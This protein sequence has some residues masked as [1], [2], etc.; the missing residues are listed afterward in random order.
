MA[1]VNSVDETKPTEV[2]ATTQSV[3][4]NFSV[5][6]TSDER[7]FDVVAHYGADKTGAT[8]AT[9]AFELAMTD[10]LA[11]GVNVITVPTGSYKMD[12][13]YTIPYG[14]H[15]NFQ[16]DA[17]I[18]VNN[19]TITLNGTYTANGKP[20]FDYSSG[21]SAIVNEFLRATDIKSPSKHK[22]GNSTTWYETNYTL[23]NSSSGSVSSYSTG[24]VRI[25]SEQGESLFLELNFTGFAN[26]IKVSFQDVD[27]NDKNG[28]SASYTT[29]MVSSV[30]ASSEL[31][32]MF[33]ADGLEKKVLIE[34][35]GTPLEGGTFNEE[36][37]RDLRRIKVVVNS[38]VPDQDA[39]FT[40]IS[41]KYGWKN[42]KNLK[43]K[44]P[45]SGLGFRHIS[46]RNANDGDSTDDSYPLY[47]DTSTQWYKKNLDNFMLEYKPDSLRLPINYKGIIPA[48]VI[49]H[50]VLDRLKE[51]LIYASKY[52]LNIVI[53]LNHSFT[54]SGFQPTRQILNA[55]IDTDLEA[56]TMAGYAANVVEF[57][58]SFPNI[59]GWDLENEINFLRFERATPITSVQLDKYLSEIS[60]EVLAV[61]KK[62]RIITMSSGINANLFINWALAYGEILD[63]HSYGSGTGFQNLM[64]SDKPYISL[65]SGQSDDLSGSTTDLTVALRYSEN[66]GIWNSFADSFYTGSAY[67]SGLDDV[68]LAKN[69]NTIAPWNDLPVG[70][71]LADDATDLTALETYIG[72]GGHVWQKLPA[73]GEAAGWIRID[74]GTW[75]TF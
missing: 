17:K 28:G 65:E 34:V 32:T 8:G 62:P 46:M 70:N 51:F 2:S 29:Q 36:Y 56:E 71:F 58:N 44:P 16:G 22:G 30:P 31:K 25:V 64:F 43:I 48:G 10:A 9:T 42:R 11:A 57:I 69:P 45:K 24:D 39:N 47:S 33:D 49:D 73:T 53:S 38:H 55:D 74:D 5:L 4:D 26:Q 75:E 41:I 54:D 27:G 37:F 35:M 19:Q 67:V 23:T 61:S 7:V 68:F 15:I 12:A 6:K 18:L 50:D 14:G 66:I 52:D 3:R 59:Y 40:L 63:K 60:T 13:S 72:K 20:R 1:R 21:G